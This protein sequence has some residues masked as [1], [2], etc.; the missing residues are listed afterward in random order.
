MQPHN[1]INEKFDIVLCLICSLDHQ[2]ARRLSHPINYHPNWVMLLSASM[3]KLCDEIHI[4]HIRLPSRNIDLLSDTSWFLMFYLDLLVNRVLTHKVCSIPLHSIPLID[5]SQI[6]VH[7]SGT[8]MNKIPGV[9][10]FCKNMLP[11]LAHIRS[12]QSTLVEKYTISPLGQ[13]PTL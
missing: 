7:L 3:R 6:A 8:C 5:F 10:S 11:R 13:N 2:K 4:D 1:F 9:M 12:T